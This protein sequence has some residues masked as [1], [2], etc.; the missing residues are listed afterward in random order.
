MNAEVG[1]VAD[2]AESGLWSQRRML[3]LTRFGVLGVCAAS[4]CIA[5]FLGL[6][7]GNSVLAQVQDAIGKVA[8]ASYTVTHTTGEHQELTW[9]VKVLGG[10]LCRVE[11]PNGIYLIF[12][13]KGKRIMEVDPHESKVRI[14]QNVPVP[15][16]FD[17]ISTLSNVKALA[18]ERQPMLPNREID[19]KNATGIIIEENGVQ[20]DVWI[21]PA[22]HLPLEMRRRGTPNRENA[23][24]VAETWSDF[25]FDEPL[26]KSLFAFEVPR[27]FAVD[28]RQ[29]PEPAK[30]NTPSYGFGPEGRKTKAPS[31]TL[32]DN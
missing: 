8:T 30:R 7:G 26:D 22:T 19:G 1:D 23:S 27:G 20:F 4:I 32:H 14:T 28:T 5:L 24:P 12:D 17:V 11:Q 9:T 15:R 16:N 21:D 25:H 13:V 6:W 10:G 3:M 29:S 18:V 2:A 31:P